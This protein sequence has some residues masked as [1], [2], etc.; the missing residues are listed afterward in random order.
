MTKVAVPDD[1][2]PEPKDTHPELVTVVEVHAG[3]VELAIHLEEEEGGVSVGTELVLVFLAEGDDLVLGHHQMI[4]ITR[5]RREHLGEVRILPH[6]VD[7][8]GGFLRRLIGNI[9]TP[10]LQVGIDPTSE[11]VLCFRQRLLTVRR[12]EKEV[13]VLRD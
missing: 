7:R 3:N 5:K 12:R 6:L 13:F 8:D 10:L 1:A 4:Q 9:G 2:A 11:D